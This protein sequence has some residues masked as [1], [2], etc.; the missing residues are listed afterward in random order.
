MM[1]DAQERREIQTAIINAQE[2]RA[3]YMAETFA[4]MF[5]AIKQVFV[6]LKT[7]MGLP[8]TS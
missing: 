4:L 7:P 2:L 3:A 5:A 8:H 1:N 6:G